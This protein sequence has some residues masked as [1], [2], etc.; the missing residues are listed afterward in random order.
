MTQIMP[1]K[2]LN[3]NQ[4]KLI[5]II[6]MTIDHITWLFFRGVKKYNGERGEWKGRKCFL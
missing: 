3:S 6:A 2:G 5:E 4:I 1:T